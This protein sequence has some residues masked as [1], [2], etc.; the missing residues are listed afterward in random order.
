MPSKTK[1]IIH[2]FILLWITGMAA[3]VL[4]CSIFMATITM[5]AVPSLI[6]SLLWVVLF[7]YANLRT[8][9]KGDRYEE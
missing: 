3:I 9:K 8:P 1:T 7:A 4:G 6:I 2:N 5:A